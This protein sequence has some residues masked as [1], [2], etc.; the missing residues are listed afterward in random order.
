MCD[1]K[2]T[3][4]KCPGDGKCVPKEDSETLCS[5]LFLGSCPP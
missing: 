2:D 1:C 5:Y 3:E 4:F